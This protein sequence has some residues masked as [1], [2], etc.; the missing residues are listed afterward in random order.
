MIRKL[1]AERRSPNT[2]ITP[3]IIPLMKDFGRHS[4]R[5]WNQLNYVA[6]EKSYSKPC[7]LWKFDKMSLISVGD[8]A[9]A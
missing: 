8:G 9:K 2:D 6:Q 1:L 5:V 4:Q 3:D 7:Y